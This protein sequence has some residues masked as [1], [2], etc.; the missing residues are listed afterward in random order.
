MSD[1]MLTMAFF[2]I[3]YLAMV[4]LRGKHKHMF[5]KLHTSCWVC[6]GLMV[7][8][9]GVGSGADSACQVHHQFSGSGLLLVVNGNES[10]VRPISFDHCILCC[11]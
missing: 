10:N 9:H 8:E 5:I 3:Q 11:Y 6:C 1:F 7:G 4:H 2:L